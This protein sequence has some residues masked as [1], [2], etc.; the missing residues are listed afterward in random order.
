MNMKKLNA[1]SKN[2]FLPFVYR[3]SWP[4][5]I[6]ASIVFLATLNSCDST[7]EEGNKATRD[8]KQKS[9]TIKV[10][11]FGGTVA[12]G[13]SAKLDLFHD[14]FKHGTTTVNKVK[15]TQTWWSILERILTDWVE[16]NVEII[17]S[18]AP[19]IAA[20]GNHETPKLS[21]N[22]KNLYL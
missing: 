2:N 11:T 22:Y 12:E 19:V 15:K 14:C 6:L 17:N 13:T 21:N 18:I 20:V 1:I 4:T 9:E 16:G 3:K 7:Q 8:L 5:L 10:I